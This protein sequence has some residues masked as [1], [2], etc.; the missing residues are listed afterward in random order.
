VLDI[1]ANGIYSISLSELQKSGLD[2]SSFSMEEVQLSQSGNPVPYYI[3]ADNLIFYGLASADRYTSFRPYILHTGAAGQRMDTQVVE[4]DDSQLALLVHQTLHVEENRLY[5]AESRS[6]EEDDV[7]FWQEIGQGQKLDLPI[8]LSHVADAPATLQLQL[9]GSTH[10]AQVE[11]DHDFDL[12]VNGQWIDTIRWDGQTRFTAQ[13]NLAADVLVPGNNLLTLDN[14]VAGAAFLDIIALNWLELSYHSPPQAEDDRLSFDLAQG[15]ASLQGFTGEPVIFDVSDTLNPRLLTGW[16]YLS[17]Q[18]DL[19]VSKEMT[20]AAVGPSGFMR[21]HNIRPLRQS[22]WLSTDNQADLIIIADDDLLPALNPLVKARQVQGLH[23][24][25]VPIAEIYD[26]FGHG[27]ATPQ[28]ISDFVSYAYKSW[29]APRPRYLLLV[30]DATSDYRDNLGRAPRFH[31]PSPMVPVAYSG[32]TVSD[33][34]LV[35]IDA[36]GR[37]DLAVG[38]WPVGEID[39]VRSLVERTLVYERGD[40]NERALF[41]TD[42]TEARFAMLAQSLWTAA[43]FSPGRAVSLNGASA[44]QVADQWNEGAWLV[45]YIGHGSVQQWGKDDLFNPEAVGKLSSN[46][47]QPIVL[48]LTCLTGL[49]AHPDLPSISETMLLHPRGPVLVIAATSLTLS[50]DQE[51]LA[52]PLLQYLQDPNFERIGDAFQAAKLALGPELSD[53]LREVSDTYVLLG[54]PSAPIVRP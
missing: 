35:D 13:T 54:D 44:G 42:G 9:Y 4:T 26:A 39:D 12:I 41:A 50:T 47:N 33:S 51:A 16:E 38:R 30:G 45:T 53:G 28:S 10:N 32:E 19:V 24:V 1:S 5:L 46:D 21:P 6:S 18:V 48:Q 31:I 49:F 25:V 20:I 40:A 2:I 3:R 43:E 14:E 17:G 23:A 11:N 29:R 22:D 36:D 7:W 52:R 8:T 37:P 27:S 15:K 34:R